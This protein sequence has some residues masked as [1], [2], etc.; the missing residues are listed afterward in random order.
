MHIQSS[1]KKVYTVV[2]QLLKVS[3][4]AFGALLEI[5]RAD[6]FPGY[7]KRT[8]NYSNLVEQLLFNT[9]LL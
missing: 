1:E 7:P 8:P 3:S 9:D 2:I 4:M 5:S 6:I